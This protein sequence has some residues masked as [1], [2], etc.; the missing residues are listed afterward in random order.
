M[1]NN[2]TKDVFDIDLTTVISKVNMVRSNTKA[3]WIDTGTTCYVCLDKKMFSTFDLIKTREKVFMENSTTSKIKGQGKVVLKMT[4]RKE[5]TLTNVLYVHE[6]CKNLVFG[7][8]LNSHG[9]RM[10]F[11]SNQFVLSKSGMYIGKWYMSN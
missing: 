9:F 6:I 11:E 4:S 7:S 8:L 5:V 2:I 1:V 3:W 10:V